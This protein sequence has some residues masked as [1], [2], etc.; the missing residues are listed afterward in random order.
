[1]KVNISMETRETVDGETE[2]LRHQAVGILRKTAEGTKVSYTMDGVHHE[3][4]VHPDTG[5]VLIIRNRDR[6]R[7][8]RYERNVHHIV[9]Y[10]TPVGTM[11]LGFDTRDVLIREDLEAGDGRMEIKLLY[12][13]T[14]FGNPV[15]DCQLR[16][17]ISPAQ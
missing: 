12:R 3:L 2:V 17:A 10:E 1:L 13:L 6:E 11:E 14:Q 8:L 15:A 4:E 9:E 16:I 7:L 5:S